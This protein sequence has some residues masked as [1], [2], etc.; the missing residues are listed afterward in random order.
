MDLFPENVTNHDLAIEDQG[1]EKTYM[2]RKSRNKT[3]KFTD[4]HVQPLSFN[5]STI[6]RLCHPVLR[7][8]RWRVMGSIGFVLSGVLLEKRRGMRNQLL[9]RW[10]GRWCRFRWSW[11]LWLLSYSAQHDHSCCWRHWCTLKCVCVCVVMDW[12]YVWVGRID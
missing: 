5:S 1:E 4:G 3:Q 12:S 11:C 7:W 10:R 6:T 8:P 9:Q 2:H